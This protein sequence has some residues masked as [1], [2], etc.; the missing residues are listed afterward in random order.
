MANQLVLDTPLEKIVL[1]R[2]TAMVPEAYRHPDFLKQLQQLSDLLS[3]PAAARI[4][5]G[6]DQVFRLP[7][8]LGEQSLD[9]AVK[10][11]KRQG[12]LKDRA[13]LFQGSKAERSYRNAVYLR[14]KRIGTPEP[15]AC[16][17]V[18]Q[19][20]RLEQSYYLSLYEPAEN[21]RDELGR[22]LYQV[23]DHW[24]VMDLLELVAPAVK[25]MHQAGFVHRDLGNQNILLP[26]D[27]EGGWSQPLFVDLN[28]GRV[29][30]SISERERAFD[31]SRLA[32]PG[33]YLK[34]FKYIY[35][36]HQELSAQ[37]GNWEHRYRR[38]FARHQRSQ[39]WRHPLRSLKAIA[40]GNRSS[41]DQVYPAPR[42]LWLWDEKSAQPMIAL[43]RTEKNRVRSKA[44]AGAMLW[45]SLKAAPGVW[46]RYKRLL[47]ESF[48]QKLSMAGR[49]GV[50][51]HPHSDY[52]EPELAL[53]LELGNP[54]VLLRFC[55]HE[56][57]EI[58]EDTVALIDKLKARS[59]PVMVAFVQDRQALLEPN[60][61]RALL[62]SVI[63]RIVDQVEEI[64]IGHAINRVKWGVWNGAEYLR[65]IE[66]ALELQR[67]YP[68]IRLTGPACIDF[69]YAPVIAALNALPK[70]AK[71]SAVS[72]HLYVD[73]RGYPENFQGAFSTLEK[74]A[75]LKAIAQWSPRSEDRVIVSEVN[76]P[77]KG[78][79][80]WSPVG[81]G[82]ESPEGRRNPPGETERDCADY[83]L[84]YY[85]L[86]LCSGHVDKVY[87]WRLSAHGYGLVDDRDHWR[88][89]P[90]FTALA[91][92]LRTLDQ[93][94]FVGRREAPDNCYL[95]E[96]SRAGGSILVAWSAPG[97][98][99]YWPEFDADAVWDLEGNNCERRTL[100]GS[101]VY[102]LRMGS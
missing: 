22:V 53:L 27:P 48:K 49:V 28:R 36:D 61:W 3:S 58:W 74:C 47:A 100:T 5:A 87:W 89:R 4:S 46:P 86:A 83:M 56:N 96:F 18:W 16:F 9:V 1:A 90:A 25:A 102:L 66:P 34:I 42:D 98:V 84:R 93:A 99:D 85:L 19:G 6:A 38:R 70:E 2:G 41:K 63:P 31:L 29:V 77:V 54:P 88:K 92:F 79:S 52:I 26:R 7:M 75:L 73:R 64:E 69:E 68:N 30:E 94:E 43:S 65:L 67:V 23:R 50:A 45:Q 21:F 15:L 32:L 76:W 17:D 33:E 59:V 81:A 51:L 8:T 40:S 57:S 20:K 39:R 101:P 95:L 71:L 62:E 55:H 37:L 24:A 78:T 91:F 72:H 60:S 80:I 14:T 13:D 97:E 44:Q 12:F 10:R 35:S 11:F 82:Y